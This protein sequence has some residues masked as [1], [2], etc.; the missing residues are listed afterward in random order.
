VPAKAKGGQNSSLHSAPALLDFRR[1]QVIDGFIVDFYCHAAGLVV[2]LDG[3]VHDLQPDY[4][5]ERDT[6][7][8]ARGLRLLHLCDEGVLTDLAS[9][10]ERIFNACQR[11]PKK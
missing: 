11:D 2:E 3:G 4:D 5:E 9:V 7:L 8:L 1:Q 6:V 10:L